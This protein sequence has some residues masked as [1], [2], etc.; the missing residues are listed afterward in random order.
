M[1]KVDGIYYPPKDYVE[2]CFVKDRRALE[3]KAKKDPEGFWSGIADELE[4]FKKWDKVL[5]WNPPFA[6]WF[7]GGKCNI[8]H[9]ALDRHIDTW[10]RNKAAIIWEGECGDQR[11]LTYLQL[12]NEVVKFAAALRALGVRKGEHVTIYLPRIPEQ[13]IAM[14]AC[15]KLGA[16]HSVVYGGFSID[17]L[18]DRIIDA[19][20]RV[21]ITADGGMRNG[22]VIEFKKIA[23]ESLKSTP[24]IDAVI[25]I[26]NLGIDV[27]MVNGRDIFYDVLM[28]VP[29]RDFPETRVMDANDPLFILYT[30]GTTGKPK[31]VVHVHGGYMVGTYITTKWVFD[32]RDDDIYWC[33]ADPGWITGHS[34][35]AYGPL[36]N[37][38]TVFIYEGAPYY[39]DPGRWWSLIEKHKVSIFYTAPTAIRGLMRHGDDWPNRYD[40]SS[41]R[42][43][44]SV[45][46]PINPRA[47]YWFYTIIG[48]RRLPIMDT[49][50]Q[51]ET[52]M[53]I[54][55]PFPT[56]PLKP[57]SATFPFPGIEVD[58]LDD[59][60][61]PVPVNQGGNL[62]IK[63]PWPAMLQTIY[64]D[65]ERYKKTYW[66]KFPGVYATG[67]SAK[68]DEDGYIWIMGRVDEVIKVSGYRFGT[69]EIESA[70][71]SHKAVSEAAVIGKPH[72]LKGNVIKA[73]VVLKKESQPST[74][75]EAEE[76]KKE[77]VEHVG[78]RMGPIAKPEEIEFRDELPKTRSGK[79]MRRVL[80]AQELGLPVGDLST[81]EKE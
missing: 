16:V 44:G 25:V 74:P 20:S 30:S 73:F 65:P 22:K 28:K 55:T 60:G 24:S 58:I 23:D 43:L 33:T 62:V 50:W 42:L 14:L 31:G 1:L 11:S 35:I 5:E 51:T 59:D 19:G 49:W 79:I 10:R 47:W 53:F 48:K 78:K 6:K 76:L 26:R 34:Y 39:P 67:D 37:G 72:E 68:R 57:G 61:N 21:L 18:R 17:A 13:I 9:N 52:G 66:E 45:G 64:K 4:W 32:M 75:Q 56:T 29:Y 12:Y 63:N 27:H 46:E 2:S 81:L 7:Y 3:E 71:V 15:A 38:A 40:L 8:V 41:L 36:L 70:I 77:I 54:I 69:A 80:K